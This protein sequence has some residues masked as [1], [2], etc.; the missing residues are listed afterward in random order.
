V[1]QG[2]KQQYV[3]EGDQRTHLVEVE[4]HVF[5]EVCAGT[6]FAKA[7]RLGDTRDF[8]GDGAGINPQRPRTARV[9]RRAIQRF[10]NE[11]NQR[12]H[13][14]VLHVSLRAWGSGRLSVI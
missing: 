7:E 1:P 6:S 10:T 11:M 13:S 14:C 2:R 8:R 9:K 5:R 12:E 4:K 3:A